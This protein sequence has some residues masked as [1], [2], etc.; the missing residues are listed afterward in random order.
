MYPINGNNPVANI[1]F[2]GLIKKKYYRMF[3]V[4]ATEE[5]GVYL[6]FKF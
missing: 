6:L 1:T 5:L 4:G 2:N 3:Y